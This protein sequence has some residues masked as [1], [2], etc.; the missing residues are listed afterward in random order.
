[1]G[2]NI[3]LDRIPKDGKISIVSAGLPAPQQLV[4]REFARIRRLVEIPPSMRGW[5]VEVLNIIRR[6][7]KSRFV[8]QELYALEADLKALH[9]HNQNVR[10]KIRQQLQL[11]R[12]FD[13]I[14]FTRRGNYA[15]RD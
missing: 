11:L 15:V 10:A 8:L 14:E 3:L 12:D 13:I 4:R 7:G 2:C 1:V 6:L 9:P 5:T